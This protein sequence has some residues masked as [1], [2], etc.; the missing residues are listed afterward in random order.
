M[1]SE[2]PIDFQKK[3]GEV[4]SK[5]ES[6]GSHVRWSEHKDKLPEL[7]INLV[8]RFRG[9]DLALAAQSTH[10]LIDYITMPAIE[11]SFSNDDQRHE[12]LAGM[13]AEFRKAYSFNRLR[14]NKIGLARLAIGDFIVLFKNI[15]EYQKAAVCGE[16]LEET[17]NLKKQ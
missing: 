16:L 5:I 4:Y 9:K 12:W 10:L 8:D 2:N 11:D 3:F 17:R 6:L 14:D 15:G 13:G 7:K 1:S